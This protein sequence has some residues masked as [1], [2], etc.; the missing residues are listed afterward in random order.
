MAK[1]SLDK[2]IVIITVVSA[3]LLQLIDYSIV[4]VTLSDMMAN[5]GA[6]L[7][8]ISW[9]VTGYAAANVIMITMS[10]WLSAKLGRKNYFTASIVL[11]T[12]ASVFCGTSTTIGQLI[13]F[14]VIQGIGGGGLLSTAQ[15]I[16][17]DS[18]PKE[19]LGLANA[20]FGMG[21]IIGPSIGP[22]LGGYITD[23]LSWHWVFFVN[24]PVGIVATALSFL[25]IKESEHTVKAGRMDWLALA[26]LVAFIASLQ[27]LLE[28]GER[29]DWFETTY[30]TVLSVVS[31]VAGIF[32]ILRQLAAKSPI[33]NLH[34]MK[35]IQF[36]VGTFFSFI[37]GVGL[38][39]SVFIIP[40][41]CQTLLGYTAE[42]T[43][44]IL[45]PGSLA[46]GAM[47]PV[48][49]S[50]MKKSKVSPVLL[51]GSGFF[52]FIV[53]VWYLSNMTLQT[54]AASFFWPLIL[55][56]VG[57]GL[58]FIPLLTITIY[59][60]EK[61]DVPQGTALTNMVRQLG[62]SFG[63]ALAATYIS[64]RSKF[65]FNRLTDSIS[66]YDPSTWSR[67]N[68]F[69]GFFVSKG[70]DIGHAHTQAVA[71]LKGMV[72]RQAMVLTYDDVFLVIGIFFAIC[73]PLLLLFR[74]KN[75]SVK[76][77][78]EEAEMHLAE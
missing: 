9:V 59:P 21:V 70:S 29:E 11:F 22:T 18:F 75:K 28:R 32:F 65:H 30:I 23:H 26:M 12:V 25:Y 42:Q 76:S 48:A 60:L 41:F 53:F 49:A 43:G 39:A 56:G 33:L 64:S 67:L 47:M 36:A 68:G 1:I 71:A 3:S 46:A 57:L 27:V 62:G 74:L 6:N 24:I 15:A 52:L 37:Q 51:A 10:G 38:Y 20:I 8:D 2:W 63:I 31:V 13:F 72:M 50:L 78:E 58:I 66:A 61:K 17:I 19:E 7:G 54:S 4:N 45:M 40:V 16:L 73:I 44:L 55:R 14:R 69:T 34:L 5:L 35:N 77:A